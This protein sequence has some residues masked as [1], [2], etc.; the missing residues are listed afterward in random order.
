MIGQRRRAWSLAAAR[1]P[2]LS[3]T[4]GV[5][6]RLRAALDVTVRLSVT[7]VIE[8]RWDL[9]EVFACSG[10]DPKTNSLQLSRRPWAPIPKGPLWLAP[11]GSGTF[12]RH[13][14]K[15]RGLKP[16]PPPSLERSRARHREQGA[17]GSTTD[18]RLHWRDGSLFS[19]GPPFPKIP[20]A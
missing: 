3:G 18:D 8:R 16:L 9:A 13:D 11:Y 1:P 14:F 15:S 5:L 10:T 20:G 12:G 6:G 4:R 17:A 19:W 2:P 7:C